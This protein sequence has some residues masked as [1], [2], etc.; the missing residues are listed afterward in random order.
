MAKFDIEYAD[1]P[2]NIQAGAAYAR[3]Q[4][5]EYEAIAQAG[6]TIF[7]IGSE[8]Q[9]QK[10][11]L[12]YSNGQRQ[13]SE[14]INS[15]MSSLT[16]DEKID[17]PII[18]KLQQDLANVKVGNRRVD[19]SL[20][21]YRNNI[22]PNVMESARQR[23]AILLKNNIHDEFEAVGQ[24]FLA[25]GQLEN[26]Q[27]I[28]DRRLESKDITITQYESM[29]KS[30]FV[31]SLLEQSRDLIASGTPEGNQTAIQMLSAVPQSEEATTEKK[32]YANKLLS[33]AQKN[34]GDLSEEANKQLTDLM[35]AGTIST[36][37]VVKRRVALS[38]DDYQSWA[39]IAMQPVDKRGNIIKETELKTHAID[40]WRGTLSRTNLEGMIR[41]SLADPNG[42]N[43]RQYAAIYED[44]NREVK[45]YQAQDTKSYSMAAARV[46]LGKDAGVISFDALGNM[47]FDLQKLLSPND[48]FEQKMH[49]I[50]LYNR[51]MADYLAENPAASKKELYVK[52]QELRSTYLAASKGETPTALAPK[53]ISTD[54][55][56]Q[57]LQPGEHFIGP[58]G[59]ERVK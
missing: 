25:R 18:E 50:D 1:K 54:E 40:V 43:E 20:T 14:Y 56:W 6:Q 41:E 21:M 57:L 27:E 42:I 51:D 15:A 3:P 44:L 7:Q 19:Q 33:I 30:A 49:F 37:E 11:A 9:Q 34:S 47:T 28:L 16:G 36:E 39:K 59:I 55:E 52:A 12:D 22:L 58:D 48:V 2:V 32:E 35:I 29:T 13:I 10:N 5:A 53:R 31:D 46:I 26:Y 38:D 17:Q 45:A 24:T 23:H 8:L 4:T